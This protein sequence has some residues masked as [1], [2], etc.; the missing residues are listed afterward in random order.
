MSLW[1]LAGVL[2]TDSSFLNKADD[3]LSVEGASHS[4]QSEDVCPFS[5]MFVVSALVLG[6][7]ELF[8]H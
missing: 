3:L 8:P 5:D 7:V 6:P 1:E 4:W 2:S